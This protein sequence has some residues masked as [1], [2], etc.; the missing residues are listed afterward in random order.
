MERRKVKRMWTKPTQIYGYGKPK[1]RM[2]E[3][4]VTI[5][6]PVIVKNVPCSMMYQQI[7]SSMSQGVICLIHKGWSNLFALFLSVLGDTTR[8]KVNGIHVIL[9]ESKPTTIVGHVFGWSRCLQLSFFFSPIACCS[10]KS[11]CKLLG[12]SQKRPSMSQQ[13][14]S[15]HLLTARAA[16]FL[17][18]VSQYLRCTHNKRHLD[19]LWKPG[20]NPHEIYYYLWYMNYTSY[21][22][23]KVKGVPFFVISLSGEFCSIFTKNLEIGLTFF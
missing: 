1:N 18:Y 10:R 15:Q 19:V 23:K 20:K 11:S 2:H 5:A 3:Y 6:G 8:S 4:Y 16:L 14:I 21:F 22:G 17:I 7:A 13:N 12:M 9:V